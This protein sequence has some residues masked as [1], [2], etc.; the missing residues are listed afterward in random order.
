MI[1]EDGVGELPQNAECRN[2][3]ERMH[4]EPQLRTNPATAPCTD[5]A[6][7]DTALIT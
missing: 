1:A 2:I 5:A 3:Y 4:C 7:V 6:A